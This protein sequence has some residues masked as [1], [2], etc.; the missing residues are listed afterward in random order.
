MS[1]ETTGLT[2]HQ[3]VQ[4]ERER[5]AAIVRSHIRGSYQ[6]RQPAGGDVYLTGAY[7]RQIP[8]WGNLVKRAW[9]AQGPTRNLDDEEVYPGFD[10]DSREEESRQFGDAVVIDSMAR[11]RR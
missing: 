8:G 2:A 5:Q 6:D 10:P 9:A 4:L 3:R 1:N 11:R 7:R